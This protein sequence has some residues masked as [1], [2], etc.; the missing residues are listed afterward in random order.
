MAARCPPWATRGSGSGTSGLPLSSWTRIN[1]R[2][3]LT[4]FPSAFSGHLLGNNQGFV[5]RTME[6]SIHSL[7][8]FS[9]R[10]Q[11]RGLDHGSFS[12]DP[13]RLQGVEPR[14]FDGQGAR[15]EPQ[16]LA[17]TFDALVVLAEP[18]PHSVA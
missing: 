15:H 7:H 9:C 17:V 5:V 16:T 11:T 14:T 13:M 6:V 4:V 10:Q 1:Q 2:R 8:Q 18:V 3:R 12:M